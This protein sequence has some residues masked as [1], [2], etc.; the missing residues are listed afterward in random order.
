M[1]AR[2][3]GGLWRP[4]SPRP[5]SRFH[6]PR[7][8]A[9]PRQ[10]SPPP[11][12]RPASSWQ[13]GR[14]GSQT[15][16]SFLRERVQ[17]WGSGAAQGRRRARAGSRLWTGQ[18]AGAGTRPGPATVTSGWA[19]REGWRGG[20]GGGRGREGGGGCVWRRRACVKGDLF[21]GV[22]FSLRP[23]GVFCVGSASHTPR[24]AHAASPRA[25]TTTLTGAR[26]AASWWNGGASGGRNRKKEKHAVLA[27]G[28]GTRHACVW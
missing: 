11:A 3:G 2:R 17:S 6:P 4:S 23:P 18:E 7:S 27:A 16:A 28:P 19:R 15:R 22:I 12:P 21:E 14:G 13:P 5:P 1:W 20:R 8:R 24:I 26:A 25:P 10:T 9:A